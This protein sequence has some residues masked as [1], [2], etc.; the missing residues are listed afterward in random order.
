MRWGWIAG[1]LFGHPLWMSE[2]FP[3]SSFL[4]ALKATKVDIIAALGSE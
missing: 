3:S 2:Q 1:K 4:P